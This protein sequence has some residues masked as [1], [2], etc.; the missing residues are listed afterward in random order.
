MATVGGS[1]A[2]R[3]DARLKGVVC[4]LNVL[5][6]P[7]RWMLIECHKERSGDA[8]NDMRE[9]QEHPSPHSTR[10]SRTR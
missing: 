5:F 9:D 7:S 4:S 6:A 10:P 2:C 3:D 8:K 1:D